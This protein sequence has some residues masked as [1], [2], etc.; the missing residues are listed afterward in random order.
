SPHLTP[1]HI[2]FSDPG[3]TFGG[4]RCVQELRKAGYKGEVQTCETASITHGSRKLGAVE[5]VAV[6][7]DSIPAGAA[8][9]TVAK[10]IENLGFAAFP[11]KNA[12]RLFKLLQPIYPEIRLRSSVLETAFANVN[13]VFHPPGMILNAGWVEFTKG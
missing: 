8:A 9:V 12:E 13:A 11:G 6:S 5:S 1:D 3:H 2:I 4:L 10:Y 7:D